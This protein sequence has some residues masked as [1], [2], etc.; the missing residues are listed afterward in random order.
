[1]KRC[2]VCRRVYSDEALKFC[3]K[4]GA[5]LAPAD[6]ADP[7]T[8]TPASV[9]DEDATSTKILDV[10]ATDASAR[11]STIHLPE[12]AT[13]GRLTT[14]RLKP[15]VGAKT[16]GGGRRL[17]I[18]LALLASV[19]AAVGF[20]FYRHASNTEV[21]IESIAVLPFANQS[22][23]Q[24]TEYLSDGLTESIINSLAQLPNLRVVPRSS[25]FRYKGQQTDPLVAGRQLGV[26]A[27]LVG[28]V[29]QRA[30]GLLVSAEL[31]DVRD[32]KQIWGDRFNRKLSDLLP[33]QQEISRRISERLKLSLTGED[34]RRVARNYTA[35][36]EAYQLYLRGRYYWNKRTAEDLKTATGLFQKAIDKDPDYALAY[37]GLADTYNVFSSYGVA[38]PREAYPKGKAA[39]ESALAIDDTLAEAH[40]ALGVS[41]SAHDWNWS[42]AEDELKRAIELNPNYSTAHYFYSYSVLTPQGRHEEAVAEMK[43]AQELEPLSLIINTNLGWALIYAGRYKE[44]EEQ[45]RRTLELE[46]NFAPI[47]ARLADAL[48][49]AGR[50]EEAIREAVLAR[51]RRGSSATGSL[52]ASLGYAYAAGGKRAEAKR[53][54][55][56]IKTISAHSYVSAF[57]VAK[58]YAALGEKEEAFKWLQRAYEERDFILPR[59]KVEPGFDKIKSDPRF[60]DFVR[61]VNLSP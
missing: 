22:Q 25:V 3:A 31:V 37:A 56:E 20:Y 53:T 61:K 57:W 2:P 46:P 49:G 38:P 1:M 40:T 9:R 32:N 52:M 8:L 54:L 21:A 24:E 60:A 39:A 12:G 33:L 30:D 35:D 15:T 5:T 19:A 4:D 18:V 16:A 29:L 28:R 27:V 43:R 13:T 42:A 48:T 11:A 47:H 14:G 41:L 34:E 44:A 55:A 45:L 23:D 36:T 51:E 50:H 17:A 10:H 7:T 59:I 26:R 6:S 58:I